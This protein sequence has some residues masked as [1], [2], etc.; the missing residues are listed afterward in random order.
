MGAASSV[1]LNNVYIS[2]G[3]PNKYIKMLLDKLQT[4]DCSF[5]EYSIQQSNFI[6]I[7]ISQDTIRTQS[8]VAEINYAWDSKKP[9]I[10]IMTNKNYTPLCNPELNS[11]IKNDRWISCFDEKSVDGSFAQISYLLERN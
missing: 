9:I 7:C 5:N 3:S 6:I 4:L 2:K 10:Y 11:I 1:S 8:Q